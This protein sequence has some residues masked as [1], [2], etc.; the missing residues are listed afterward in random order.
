MRFFFGILLV[1]ILIFS[2]EKK[3]VLATGYTNAYLE[4]IGTEH[5]TNLNNQIF[6][7]Y[8]VGNDGL[9]YPIGDPVVPHNGYGPAG[10]VEIH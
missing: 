3:F 6:H 1:F 8:Y 2:I 4:S 7:G 10:P 9:N 5:A